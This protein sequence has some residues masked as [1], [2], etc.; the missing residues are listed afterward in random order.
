MVTWVQMY[1]FTCIIIICKV[2]VISSPSV[3]ALGLASRQWNTL[4]YRNRRSSRRLHES[5]LRKQG[6]KTLNFDVALD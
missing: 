2:L 4:R 3:K 6:P 5:L 1:D